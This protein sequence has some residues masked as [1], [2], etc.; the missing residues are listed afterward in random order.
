MCMEWELW[1]EALEQRRQQSQAKT[2]PTRVPSRNPEPR[3]ATE[4]LPVVLDAE[5]EPV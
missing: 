3:P 1:F 5:P 4:P 2:P